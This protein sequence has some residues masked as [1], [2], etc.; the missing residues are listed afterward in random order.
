MTRN[1]TPQL[2]MMD[3]L[4]PP[5]PARERQPIFPSHR[6]GTTPTP[7]ETWDSVVQRGAD[8]GLMFGDVGDGPLG[9]LAVQRVNL[10]TAKMPC[11]NWHYSKCVP[12]VYSHVYG[13]WEHG[14]FKGVLLFGP[15]IARE[16]R[17]IHPSLDHA[18]VGELLRVALVG[19]EQPI[20][21]MLKS[22]LALLRSD[23][24]ELQLL[25][26]YADPN[27]GHVGYLYQAA[28]W[29]YLGQNARTEW[30]WVNGQRIHPRTV[31]NLYGTQSMSWLRENV[32]PDAYKV[33]SEPKYKYAL[34]LT[35][36]MRRFLST[37][38][39]PYPKR[40]DEHDPIVDTPDD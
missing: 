8:Q 33:F 38:A 21:K 27:A 23:W 28:S 3:A 40:G 25:V 7:T 17:K 22:A 30:I 9:D 14:A 16:M 10:S 19:H 6:N 4:Y 20:T 2:S 18:N 37:M 12:S 35:R 5:E 34:G 15:P 24:P 36:Q 32:D 11:E 26:S 1:K 31:V 29:V 39:L 13:V